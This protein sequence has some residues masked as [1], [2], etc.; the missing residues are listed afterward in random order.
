MSGKS[1]RDFLKIAVAG[2][3]GAALAP[4]AGRA[5]GKTVTMLHETSFIQTFDD[6]LQKTLAP[7]YEKETGVKVAYELT[8]VGSLPTRISTAVETGAGADVTMIYQLYPFLF[9]EKLADVTD[10]AT[11]IGKKQGGW[12]PAANESAVI[13]GKWKAIPHSNIGQLM[14]WRTDWFAEVGVKKFP[15]T[16]DEFYEVGKK[17]KAKGHPYGLELGHGFG[18]NHGWIY[19]LL[20]SYG[21]HEVEADGKTIVIDSAET[22]AALDFARKLFKDAILEDSLGWTDVSN[23]KAWMAEQIS[24]TNNAESILWF[25]KKN[26]PDIAKVTDQAQNPAGPKGRFHIMQTVSHAIYNFG[27]QQ[28]EAKKFLAWLMDEKQLGPWFASADTYY[29]PLAHAFDN[30]PMWQVEPRNIPYRDAMSSAHLLGWPAP[31]N[32]QLAESVAKY[33]IVDMFAK[34][35]TG[36]S[37]KDAIKSAESQLK[38]IYGTA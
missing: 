4:A 13:N 32:H 12:Y 27:P 23:N 14:N 11:E 6:Y 22:A 28:E 21:G 2:A 5:A 9:A 16:W 8:S 20:W 36:T 18:D 10:I 25:A 35:C 1:R 29:Q 37:T 33:V 30:A 38:Q 7:A 17:L 3:A 15:E 19:P 26:F 24:C 34:A 31:P